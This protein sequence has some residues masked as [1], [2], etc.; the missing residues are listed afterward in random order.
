ML[1]VKRQQMAQE[2]R[3]LECRQE[4][5]L[6]LLNHQVAQLPL[7]HFDVS[8]HLLHDLNTVFVRHLEVQ[9]TQTDRTDGVILTLTHIDY[10]VNELFA[11]VDR[12][13]PIDTN[14]TLLV[15]SKLLQVV[16]NNFYVDQLVLSHNDFTF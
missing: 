12:N 15:K 11:L 5:E 2:I 4:H 6:G 14:D 8:A 7:S 9:Q 1:D 16:L 10:L 13:L 3:G